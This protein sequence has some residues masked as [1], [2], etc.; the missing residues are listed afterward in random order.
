MA[1]PA[2]ALAE[3][4]KALQARQAVLHEALSRRNASDAEAASS[5]EA[6]F[7]RLPEYVDKLQRVQQAMDTLTARTAQMRARC[8]QLSEQR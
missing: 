1:T 2:S 3:Q 8:A 5:V 6:T 7:N 4:L